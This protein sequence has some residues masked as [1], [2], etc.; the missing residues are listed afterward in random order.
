MNFTRNFTLDMNSV[1]FT[2]LFNQMA[3]ALKFYQ[4]KNVK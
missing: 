4:H 1:Y 3:Q 2:L